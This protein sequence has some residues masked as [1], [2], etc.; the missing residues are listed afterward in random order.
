MRIIELAIPYNVNSQLGQKLRFFFS[1]L[2]FDAGLGDRIERW[3]ERNPP[4][5]VR[6]ELCTCVAVSIG[7]GLRTCPC[8]S[9]KAPK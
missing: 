9:R 8:L 4:D 6:R 1:E 5:R 7:A 2:K 3:I